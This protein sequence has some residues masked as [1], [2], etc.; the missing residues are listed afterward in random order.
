MLVFAKQ[1]QVLAIHDGS[2]TADYFEVKLPRQ[3]YADADRH[4]FGTQME[5]ME[6]LICKH[7]Y[8][9]ETVVE[10]FEGSGPVSRAAIRVGRRWLY[11]ESNR[12]NYGLGSRLIAEQLE[13]S[14]KAAG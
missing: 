8:P 10:P 11:C 6:K 12:G 1:G 9:G 4:L 7:T 14:A 3:P 2:D 13:V 5:L